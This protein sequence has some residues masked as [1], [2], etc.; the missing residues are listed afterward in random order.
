MNASSYSSSVISTK[1][2]NQESDPEQTV[3]FFKYVGESTAME[4]KLF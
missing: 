2:I 4:R 1:R 3:L